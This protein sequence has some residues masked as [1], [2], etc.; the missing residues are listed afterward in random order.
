MWSFKIVLRDQRTRETKELYPTIYAD[1]YTEAWHKV[2]TTALEALEL[3]S[4][5]WY[6]DRIEN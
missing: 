2:A 3:E 1:S 6:I 4:K 5:Y